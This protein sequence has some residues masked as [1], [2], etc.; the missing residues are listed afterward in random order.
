VS[1]THLAGELPTDFAK[2]PILAT[3]QLHSSLS[4]LKN[5]ICAESVL[6]F[7]SQQNEIAI[8]L[9]IELEL[10]TPTSTRRLPTKNELALLPHNQTPDWLLGC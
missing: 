10:D 9:A 8:E 4:F 1:L 3:D 5:L 2:R 7:N 6:A